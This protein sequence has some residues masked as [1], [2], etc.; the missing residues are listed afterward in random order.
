[1]KL[2]TKSKS[3]IV[4]F[5]LIL[6]AGAIS[7]ENPLRIV[8]LA[9]S[10]T[11]SLYQLGAEGS[12]VGVTSYCRTCSRAKIVGTLTNP[13]MEKIFS[14]QP[15]FVF[16]VQGINRP[17]TI[18]RLKDLGINVVVFKESQTFEDILTNFIELSEIVKKKD[19]ARKIVNEVREEVDIISALA[20]GKDPKRV[21]F[22]INK[23]PLVTASAGSFMNEFLKYSGSINI[24]G[25]INFT[26][27]RVSREE[28]LKRNPSAII[29]VNMGDVSRDDKKYWQTF[30]DLSAVR[31]DQ[32]FYVDSDKFCRSTPVSFLDSL[33]EITYLL[34]PELFSGKD[35]I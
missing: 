22:E 9:P 33:R 29:L 28:V 30:K 5:I 20:K 31:N 32:I 26:H 17:R 3:L 34:H 1:M 27:P 10:I 35:V 21:F 11:D 4:F 7:A 6:Y 18:E 8:S 25:D 16:T 2:L 14:L 13:N 23:R 24:F 19:K 12:L 15:N